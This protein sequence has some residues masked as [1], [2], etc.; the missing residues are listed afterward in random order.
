MRLMLKEFSRSPARVRAI[1]RRGDAATRLHRNAAL[2][3]PGF[4][5]FHL[6]TI[7]GRRR[8]LIA[9]LPA[10]PAAMISRG[11]RRADADFSMSLRPADS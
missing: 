1:R 10:E 2:W 7:Y 5:R 4:L 8:P 9:H 3:S 11:G 6:A